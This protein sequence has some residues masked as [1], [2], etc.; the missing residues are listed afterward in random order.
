[1]QS[2][3]KYLLLLLN[4]NFGVTFQNDLAVIRDESIKCVFLLTR[5]HKCPGIVHIISKIIFIIF[6]SEIK[7]DYAELFFLIL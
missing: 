6:R 5:G 3:A 7:M 4:I 1:M 2:K